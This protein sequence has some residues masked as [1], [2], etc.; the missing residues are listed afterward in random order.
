M[1]LC[2]CYGRFSAMWSLYAF[3]SVSKF[4]AL[5]QFSHDYRHFHFRHKSYKMEVCHTATAKTCLAVKHFTLQ[6]LF[7]SNIFSFQVWVQLH[8]IFLCFLF[9]VV[10]FFAMISPL[11]SWVVS[12]RCLLLGKNGIVSKAYKSGRNGEKKLSCLHTGVHRCALVI[13]WFGDKKF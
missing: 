10:F 7:S 1:L 3:V 5:S 9:W 2:P 12:L 11:I 6:V 13:N 4:S 8:I